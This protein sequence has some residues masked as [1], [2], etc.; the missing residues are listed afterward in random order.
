MALA[1]SC[2]AAAR[3]ATGLSVGV[4]L[5]GAAAAVDGKNVVATEATTSR[6]RNREQRAGEDTATTY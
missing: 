6:I 1:E 3:A 4:A 5:R 2:A